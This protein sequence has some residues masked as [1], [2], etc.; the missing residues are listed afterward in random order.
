MKKFLSALALLTAS[1]CAGQQDYDVDAGV[2]VPEFSFDA[3]V[4]IDSSMPVETL[5]ECLEGPYLYETT[6]PYAQFLHENPELLDAM[7]LC[8]LPHLVQ[9]YMW[10]NIAQAQRSGQPPEGVYPYMLGVFDSARISLSEY[11]AFRIFGARLAHSLWLEH[12][13]IVPW[14]LLDYSPQQ[15]ESLFKPESIFSWWQPDGDNFS[16]T[17]I[18]DYSPADTFSVATRAVD[19]SLVRNQHEGVVEIIKSV[20]GFR[21]GHTEDDIRLLTVGEMDVLRLAGSLN[22]PG[23]DI[24]GYFA[25]NDH[26][27][28]TF[29]FTNQVLSH[30]DNVYNGYLSNT[31]SQDILDSYDFWETN[32]F[33]H[34]KFS[35]PESNDDGAFN[36]MIHI[37]RM[38]VYNPSQSLQYDFC[39][40]ETQRYP[41]SERYDRFENGYDFLVSEFEEYVST[42]ELHELYNELFALTENCTTETPDTAE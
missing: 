32:V 8:E 33:P 30:G 28:A 23:E 18:V 40:F 6:R 13:E 38:Q 42:D 24:R 29:S 21:H 9:E 2:Q 3:G 15:L 1:A 41:A 27:T 16:M 34:G 36:S 35:D 31:P 11:E 17:H 19:L 5:E 10:Q 37:H 7:H 26:R 20:R 25:G 14:S 39:N 12:N 22:I 4:E